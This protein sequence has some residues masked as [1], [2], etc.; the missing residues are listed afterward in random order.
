MFNHQSVCCLRQEL[1]T[2]WYATTDP[3][4]RQGFKLS[5]S[6]TQQCPQQ[7]NK[8]NTEQWIQS[9]IHHPWSSFHYSSSSSHSKE[10]IISMIST[11]LAPTMPRPLPLLPLPP[12]DNHHLWSSFHYSSSS[13]YSKEFNII[14]STC[15]ASTSASSPPPS[16]PLLS[17]HP[18][19]TP[20]NS[21]KYFKYHTFPEYPGFP[22]SQKC[23]RPKCHGVLR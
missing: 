10:L 8:H 17:P 21:L 11:N 23:H 14:I 16:P 19:L 7:M 4:A 15:C 6:P 20:R 13:S 9:S 2:F 5:L 22:N 3:A 12:H 18:F 1:S